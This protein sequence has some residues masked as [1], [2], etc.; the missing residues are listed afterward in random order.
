MCQKAWQIWHKVGFLSFTLP[1]VDDYL[2]PF[3]KKKG[4]VYAS[5]DTLK[6]SIVW[7]NY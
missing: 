2:C 1:S 4:L 7:Q 6:L 3:L 5:F